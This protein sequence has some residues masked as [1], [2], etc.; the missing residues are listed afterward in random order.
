[1]VSD[2]YFFLE[3]LDVNLFKNTKKTIFNLSYK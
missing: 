1:M 2:Y 3:V